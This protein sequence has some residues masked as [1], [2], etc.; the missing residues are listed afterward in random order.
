M[1]EKKSHNQ[2]R[3]P[4]WKKWSK[5][6]CNQLTFRIYPPSTSN[7]ILYYI[8]HSSSSFGQAAVFIIISTAAAAP[9]FV[10]RLAARASARFHANI[11]LASSLVSFIYYA[12][13]LK[14]V[15][16][17]FATWGGTL[18]IFRSFASPLF[19]HEYVDLTSFACFV[20]FSSSSF[21]VAF[22]FGRGVF[23]G[24]YIHAY[25]GCH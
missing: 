14:I 18:E 11:T 2:H 5:R 16:H 15:S 25:S 24:K 10:Y 22:I 20:L 21:V 17:S 4:S 19:I 13:S 3:R 1:R 7:P 6:F 23:S 9:F 12:R 8:S